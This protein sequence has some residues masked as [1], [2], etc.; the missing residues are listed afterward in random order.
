M[1]HTKC[2][3]FLTEKNIYNLF[4]IRIKHLCPH[5]TKE[6]RVS[7][8]DS[9]IYHCEE[10]CALQSKSKYYTQSKTLSPHSSL[11]KGLA[12]LTIECYPQS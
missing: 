7:V 2:V 9:T 8:K 6:S 12:A 1:T 3:C 10:L 11:V 5:S 4:S